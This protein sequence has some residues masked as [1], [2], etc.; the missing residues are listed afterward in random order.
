MSVAL[1]AWVMI[2]STPMGGVVLRAWAW[3]WDERPETKPLTAYF[4]SEDGGAPSPV[5]AAITAPP[6]IDAPSTR[7]AKKV[8]LGAE[9]ARAVAVLTAE[10]RT[11]DGHLDVVLPRAART[12][13]ASIGAT[14]PPATADAATRET[15]LLEGLAR[16]KLHLASE[17]A[18][19]AALAVDVGHV[20][21]AV[22]RARA[23][24][25]KD[26]IT[27]A[28]LRPFLPAEHR[29]SAD[30]L[31]DGTSAL[32]IAFDMT[33]P[34]DPSTPISSR[35]G[36]RTHP[37]LGT[38]SFHGGTDLAVPTG[39]PI[40]AA[41]EGRVL[42]ATSDAV[43]GRYVKLDH[44][45][46][47]TTAYCHASELEV[48]RGDAIDEGRRIALSG[49]TGRATGPHLHFQLELHGKPVDPELFLRRTKLARR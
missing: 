8:G 36:P 24:G 27:Y 34:V 46:G 42:Q 5:L 3:A 10:G 15:A 21:F 35:F 38:R 7:V 22:D 12:S 20:E 45:H 48:G 1:A 37:V 19:L 44:G 28:E 47:L 25:A 39:T 41:A 16:L 13:F 11:V 6:A 2:T 32:A 17:E 18:A 29:R 26:P 40:H 4:Q 43:N 14:V 23:S 31:V 49:A 9:L 30:A 33:W